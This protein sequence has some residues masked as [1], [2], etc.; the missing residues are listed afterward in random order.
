VA[1]EAGSEVA[2]G[3]TLVVIEAM[4][5]ETTLQAAIA[6]TVRMLRAAV[7]QQ[8]RAGELLIEIEPR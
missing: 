5:M 3:Q 1:V 4:K 7:G 6:G 8:A 2:V